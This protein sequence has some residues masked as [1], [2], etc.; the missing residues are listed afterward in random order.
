MTAVILAGGF[1]TRIADSCRD[2]PK[3]MLPVCGKPVLEHQIHILRR[4]GIQD[5]CLVTGYLAEKIESY[6]A[7]GSQFGVHITYFREAEPLGTAGAL[8]HLA[9]KEDFLLCSGDLIFDFSL[10]PMLRQHQ[11]NRALATLFV[12]PNAHPC[13]STR[14]CVAENARI[15][16]FLPKAPDRKDGANLSN[17]GI[18]ILSP[19]LLKLFSREGRADLD[20][21]LLRPAVNTGRLFAYK[22]TEY[23]RDMGTPERY[24]QVQTDV[25]SGL[26]RRRNRSFAQKAVFLDRDGTLNV[27]REHITKP[28]Q[29]E[30]LPGAAKAIAA[31]NRKGY[32]TVLVTNQPVI[33]KGMCTQAQLR[34]VHDRLET[35]LGK[36]GAYLD[37]IYFCPHHPE[38]GFA[39]ER[40]E[41]KI[42][43]TCRKPSPGM[44]L[45]AAEDLHI[46]L[47]ESFMIGDSDRDVQAGRRAGCTPV[48]LH[49][50]ADL[51]AFTASLPPV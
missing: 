1:G 27:Y 26:V 34:T 14:V 47:C 17:A 50:S 48:L 21:D 45:Q 9:L 30:L 12:H 22:S 10:E 37:A 16:A 25:G 18:Q 6:F 23:V 20:K 51:Y 49:S 28:E 39:G 3:P 4:E 40:P 7:D 33:A 29:I 5:V 31:L 42:P 2:L 19:E 11:Q 43:C 38:K 41:Y 24:A 32:L 46:S 8:F 15:C 13:D 44:L 35:L 36:E